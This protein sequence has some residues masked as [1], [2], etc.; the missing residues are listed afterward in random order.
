MP[1]T[2][3]QVKDALAKVIDPAFEHDIVSWRILRSVEVSGE[4]VLVRVDIP[5]A[6]YPL[7]LRKE[8][9]SRIEAANREEG[10]ARFVV[11]LPATGG[12]G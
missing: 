6:A 3:A 12:V 1:I 11:S 2:E 4:D 7:A 9:Q 8:L 10:G 5:T